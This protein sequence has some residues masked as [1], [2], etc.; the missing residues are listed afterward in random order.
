[1]YLL[2]LNSILLESRVLRED[3]PL[4]FGSKYA[5]AVWV[6]AGSPMLADASDASPASL[7]QPRM[8]RITRMGS[9]VYGERRLILVGPRQSHSCQRVERS[10]RPEE[11]LFGE[12][13]A[14]QDEENHG[15]LVTNWHQS[16]VLG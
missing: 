9:W 4:T 7:N 6:A 5:L 10:A 11:G 15:P 12:P 2:S 14:R 1:V 13:P 16:L 3:R 8:A